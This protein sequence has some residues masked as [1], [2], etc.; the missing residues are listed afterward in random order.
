MIPKFKLMLVGNSNV[1]KTAFIKRKIT[2]EFEEKHITTCFLEIYSIKL[3]TNKGYIIFE[4]WEPFP[5]EKRGDLRDNFYLNSNCA[6]LMF[7]LTSKQS[8]KDIP[9]Y[10][11]DILRVCNNIPI[12]LVGN[13][14]DDNFNRKI[15]PEKICYHKKKN[16]N[17]FEI[18]SKTYQNFE[19]PWLH[20]S[21][22]LKNDENLYF[23]KEELFI[24]NYLS[25]TENNNENKKKE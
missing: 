16:L 10:Y 15:K 20:L 25:Y 9:M 3:L 8:Y 5:H 13:K 18:S 19:S 11:K 7:D 4:V 24:N 2:G 22:I 6:I 1:G 17:Y 23:V 14:S 21:R 12:V